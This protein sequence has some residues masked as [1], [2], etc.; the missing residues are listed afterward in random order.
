MSDGKKI[1]GFKYY[2][3]WARMGFPKRKGK[4]KSYIVK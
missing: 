4:S 1:S 3:D 2:K